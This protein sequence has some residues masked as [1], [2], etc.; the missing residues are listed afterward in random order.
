MLKNNLEIIAAIFLLLTVSSF[1]YAKTYKCDTPRDSKN[2]FL[3]SNT[4][5]AVNANSDNGAT[6]ISTYYANPDGKGQIFHSNYTKMEQYDQTPNWQL[7]SSGN[8][9]VAITKIY[10]SQNKFV[11]ILVT[12][13][14]Q[15]SSNYYQAICE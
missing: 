1:S 5:Y 9:T 13:G 11:K 10:T 6:L 7:Y 14:I 3:I 8:F 2:N 15:T 4:V 12:L